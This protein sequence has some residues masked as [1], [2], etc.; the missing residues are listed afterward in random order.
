M[1]L[2]HTQSRSRQKRP[3]LL[4]AENRI[5]SSFKITRSS[6]ERLNKVPHVLDRAGIEQRLLASQRLV[7][8]LEK[9]R[10]RITC[11][12]HDGVL[13]SLYAVGLGLESCG[14]LLK[15]APSEVT[16]HLKRSTAQLDQALRELRS[17]LKHDLRHEVGGEE[18][19]GRALGALVEGMTGMSSTHCRLKID[20]AAIE[21][22]PKKRQRDLLHFVREALSNCIRH[23]QAKRV[24]VTLTLK[25]GI[26]CLGISDDGIGFTPHNPPKRGLGLP[27]LTTRAAALG[28]WLRIVSAPAQGTRI[29]LELPGTL[30]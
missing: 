30:A 14:R 25:N 6:I 12:L 28:G 1:N 11:D 19:F 27:S 21:A 24:E 20:D 5:A 3:A 4:P 23:A 10:D 8:E 22:I 13:Q 15:D 17:F 18:D 29:A 26:P 9:D 2:S 16:E 7:Q